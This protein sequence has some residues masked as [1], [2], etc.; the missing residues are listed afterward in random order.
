[1]SRGGRGPEAIRR[2]GNSSFA[3]ANAVVIP[4]SGQ[5]FLGK[6]YAVCTVLIDSSGPGGLDALSRGKGLQPSYAVE[7]NVEQRHGDRRTG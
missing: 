3:R 7:R 4:V 1:M 5:I 6:E 2:P